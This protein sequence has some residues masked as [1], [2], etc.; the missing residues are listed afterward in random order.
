M[1]SVAQPKEIQGDGGL[2]SLRRQKFPGARLAHPALQEM[3]CTATP[4]LDRN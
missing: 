3:R 2:S 4:Q 1:E